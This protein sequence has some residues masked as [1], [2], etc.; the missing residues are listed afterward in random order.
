M[1]G[2]RRVVVHIGFAVEVGDSGGETSGTELLTCAHRLD[3]GVGAIEFAV[4][5]ARLDG[6]VL[7][8]IGRVALR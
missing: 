5:L 2:A 3:V 4:E 1:A 8:H 7:R 6:N